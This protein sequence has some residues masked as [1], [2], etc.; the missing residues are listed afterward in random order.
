MSG[1]TPLMATKA[2][3]IF[4][5]LGFLAAFCATGPMIWVAADIARDGF[6]AFHTAN[7]VIVLEIYLIWCCIFL[8][9]F[10]VQSR[11]AAWLHVGYAIVTWFVWIMMTYGLFMQIY[12]V[13][14]NGWGSLVGIHLILFTPWLAGQYI[15]A[16]IARAVLSLD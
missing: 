6:D 13:P 10:I 3:A 15:C 2:G 1:G 16:G 9:H 5:T 14:Y 12:Q 4:G 8:G 7:L 11:I